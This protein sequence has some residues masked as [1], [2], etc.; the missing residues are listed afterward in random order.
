LIVPLAASAH[1]TT[2]SYRSEME[3]GSNPVRHGNV[4]QESLH[5]MLVAEFNRLGDGGNRYL[6][7]HFPDGPVEP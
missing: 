4:D 2:I 6:D 7:R 3:G 1:W 5:L